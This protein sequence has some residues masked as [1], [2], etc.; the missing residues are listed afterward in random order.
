MTTVC[1]RSA[2]FGLAGDFKSTL[3]AAPKGA[4]DIASAAF[5]KA[6]KAPNDIEMAPETA[7]DVTVSVGRRAI[8]TTVR[9][10]IAFSSSAIIVEFAVL[11]VITVIKYFANS[12]LNFE[13][14]DNF[15]DVC[16][17]ETTG[18]WIGVAVS[19]KA[20]LANNFEAKIDDGTELVTPEV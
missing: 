16:G 5:E 13:A 19:K 4:G 1:T 8:L 20:K 15:A 12:G 11:T 9:V 17:C 6:P 7:D 10:W 2:G 14:F 3:E 18:F